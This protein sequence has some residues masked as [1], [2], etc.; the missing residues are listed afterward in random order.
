VN[1]RTVAPVIAFLITAV[2]VGVV[3]VYVVP[4][5]NGWAAKIP[6]VGSYASNK[7]VNLLLIGVVVLLGLNLFVQLAKKV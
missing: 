4:A 3:V 1:G 6:V 7:F 2:L 5:L